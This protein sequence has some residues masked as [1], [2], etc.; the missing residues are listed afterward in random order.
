[1]YEAVEVYFNSFLILAL[2]GYG[3]LNLLLGKAYI[4]EFIGG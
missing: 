4:T 2:D 1:M 3:L